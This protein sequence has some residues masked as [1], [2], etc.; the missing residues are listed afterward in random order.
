M[1]YVIIGGVAAGASAAAR[2]I[3]CDMAMGVMGCSYNSIFIPIPTMLEPLLHR[4]RRQYHS[5]P[6]PRRRRQ[7]QTVRDGTIPLL[8]NDTVCFAAIDFDK[9]SWRADVS[10]VVQILRELGLPVAVERSRSGNGA[11]NRRPRRRHSLRKDRR[12]SGRHCLQK[13]QHSDT[14]EQKAARGP[15]GGEAVPVS[16]HTQE[17]HRHLG[18]RQAP[19]HRENRH[20]AHSESD[21][22]GTDPSRDYRILWTAHRR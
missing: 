5:E 6:P 21:A 4:R 10:S 9:A 13:S 15:M 20:C 12:G 14:S 7:G 2:L 18:W 17:G 22:E 16:W 3:A 1:K 19:L 8:D 11:H